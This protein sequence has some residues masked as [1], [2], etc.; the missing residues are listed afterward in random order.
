ML[1]GRPEGNGRS[2]DGAD[3][4]G[5]GAGQERLDLSIGSNLIEMWCTGDGRRLN[6]RTEAHQSLGRLNEGPGEIG[7]LEQEQGRNECER[8]IVQ[9]E[10]CL[11]R[12][13][14]QQTS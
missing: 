11:E 12:H 13:H 9:A 7:V 14:H 10:E 5:T 2:S 6:Q 8:G 1:E 4:G 3:D